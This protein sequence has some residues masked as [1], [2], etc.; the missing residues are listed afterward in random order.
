M[1]E[2][3][4]DI[5]EPSLEPP[6]RELETAIKEEAAEATD[7]TETTGH[8]QSRR[9]KQKSKKTKKEPAHHDCAVCG[10]RL[11]NRS[12]LKRHEKIHTDHA[13]THTKERPYECNV[14]SKRFSIAG[15]MQR[16]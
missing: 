8:Q 9:T 6:R 14:C 12:D 15:N 13:R 11:K 10:K 2:T 1:A 7:E 5:E 3:K 16:H 4:M